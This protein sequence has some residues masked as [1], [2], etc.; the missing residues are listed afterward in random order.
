MRQ[1]LKL[2]KV[3][4]RRL[5]MCRKT[6]I[7]LALNILIIGLSFIEYVRNAGIYICGDKRLS[8]MDN[9]VFPYIIG[10]LFGSLIWGIGILT[11]SDRVKKNGV[12]DMMRAFVDEK[13]ASL[14]RILAYSVIILIVLGISLIIYLPIC[15]KK[16]D[17]LFSYESYFIYPV[18]L[19]IPCM[20]IT[21]FLLEG[22][23][24]ISE[25][26]SVSLIIFFILTAVQ[27][28]SPLVENPFISWNRPVNICISDAFGSPAVIR[29]Q[30]YTRVLLMLVAIVLW[31]FS[32]V[33]IR[34][35]QYNIIRSFL[36]RVKKPV[37]FVAPVIFLVFAVIMVI[38]Q[39]F[40]DHSPIVSLDDMSFMMDDGA[41]ETEAE[42]TDYK[43]ELSF[44]TLLG[45]MDGTDEID[46]ST[47]S[48]DEISFT[49]G[50]GIKLKSA[51]IDG[52]PL[53]FTS[54]YDEDNVLDTYFGTKKYVLKNPERKT[55]K[56]K[57]VYGGYP[58]TSHSNFVLLGY[59]G[60]TAIG[61]NYIYLTSDYMGANM[62]SADGP[63]MELYVN[64]PSNH[65][66][67]IESDAMELVK[68]NGDGTACWK[69][70]CSSGRLLSGAYE[71]D[72]VSYSK[73]DVYFKYSKVYKDTVKDNDLDGAIQNVFNYC[74]K[75]IGELDKNSD[76]EDIKDIGILQLSAE[77]GGGYAEKGTVA[78]QED[79]LSP[80]T[81][82]D[83]R[84][85]SNVNETFT[86]E[87]VH[88]YWGDLGMPFEDDGLWSCEGLTV[89]TTYRI[90]KDKYGELYAQKYYVDEWEQDVKDLNNN[91]YYRHP[92]YLDK[93]P[94][95]YRIAIEDSVSATNK[96]SLMPLML[97]K[98]EEKLGGEEEMD[99]VLSELYST[100]SEYIEYGT[101]CTLQDFLDI[102]GLTE[103]DIS[104]E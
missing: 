98:A 47:V 101:G 99:R 77:Y 61:K 58:C 90:I 93:L 52:E 11:D 37:V 75:H 96:Y 9:V 13:K 17:Y 32:C 48:G 71:S 69:L 38:K 60:M 56:L 68:D 35:Y 5:L 31:E 70:A 78:M 55:G 27:F 103:E 91:F 100:R 89:F 92:E 84:A 59:D 2:T 28:A 63:D 81:L 94:L 79:I 8:T 97:L 33:F 54:Y 21:F 1:T 24:N 10:S 3:E 19:Y 12:N 49:L 25:N 95:S 30:L 80:Q 53:E 51:T 43:R 15:S 18:I 83:S 87:I 29:I 16:M 76:G 44:N 46:L 23:Y 102:A 82:S 4:L 64:V 22:L 67:F 34:K 45:L 88:L 26:I 42:Y 41:T 20:V 40:V 50:A 73:E 39:P 66:P 85:G 104:V 6:Y 74:D 36:I 62:L 65:T 57:L 86:H 7:M 72:K 14:S